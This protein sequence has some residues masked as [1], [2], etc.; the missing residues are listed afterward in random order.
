MLK[1][2]AVVLGVLVAFAGGLAGS[3][4]AT[5]NLSR[6]ALL[7]LVAPEPPAARQGA[8]DNAGPVA[9]MLGKER[10]EVAKIRAELEEREKELDAREQN[11]GETLSS[12]SQKHELLKSEV[13]AL[14]G[15]ELERLKDVAASIGEMKPQ[16]AGASLE[17][18]E[19]EQAANILRLITKNRGKIL[20]AMKDVEKRNLILELM[21]EPRY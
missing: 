13:N 5:G 16:E 4:A 18:M 2:I 3:L 12:L 7:K 1:L 6:E 20:D 21:Q 17:A 11:I 8:A 9:E 19:P 15:E 14:D 10:A